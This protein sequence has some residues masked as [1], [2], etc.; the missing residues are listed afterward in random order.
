MTRG[1]CGIWYCLDEAIAE[2]KQVVK[3][4]SGGTRMR[5]D[6]LERVLAQIEAALTSRE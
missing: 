1:V 5:P 6:M 2:R 3:N 4:G